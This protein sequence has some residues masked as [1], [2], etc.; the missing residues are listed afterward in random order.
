MS[1]TS[2]GKN[3]GKEKQ[4]S[5]GIS[6]GV[7]SNPYSR[8][9]AHYKSG[10]SQA[11]SGAY[12]AAG[13]AAAYSRNSGNYSAKRHGLSRGKKVAV[14]VLSVLLICLIGG[15]AAFAWYVSRIDATLSG[16]LS[17]EQRQAIAEVTDPSANFDNPFYML[18]IG[19]DARADDASIGQ[20]SDTNI[21]VY[22]D[23]KKNVV[24]MVS[25]PRDTMIEINGNMEKF[26]AAYSY[27]GPASTIREANELCGIKISH[28][29]E[30][31][32][33]NLI[34]LI[35]AVGGVEVNVPELIND[36]DAG[37]IVIQPGLQT[38]N[39]EAA[40][41]FARS[42]A[43]IDG[44]FT[45]TSNQRLLIEALI[46][47]VLSTP[48]TELPNVIQKAAESVTTD[49]SVTEIL[50][51]AMRFQ[52][53]N[54]GI[55]S[56][57]VPSTTQTVNGISYVLTYQAQLKELMRVIESGGDPATIDF[58]RFSKE[59]SDEQQ[60]LLGSYGAS[61]YDSSYETTYGSSYYGY[62]SS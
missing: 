46:K 6:R 59:Y 49:L 54:L 9:S 7:E 51:L 23:P 53:D 37:N 11:K 12:V 55:H 24:D 15:G 35:D 31:N 60:K 10:G 40:L 29:A 2:Q 58:T 50:D 52:D 34:A 22:V 41:V 16:N 20:R 43:Y 8:S 32:F 44:D 33:E 27:K 14:G 19:S 4:Y 47:K 61:T 26:N 17:D 5:T 21:L 36:P 1:R 13:N 28:Y 30:V 57:M 38:L 48:V 25:I 18:L 45:R 39:G 3:Q 62:G 42:R 56:A